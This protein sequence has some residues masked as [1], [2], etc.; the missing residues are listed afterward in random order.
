MNLVRRLK[1]IRYWIP[2]FL[3][4]AVIFVFSS[5][6]SI[7]TTDIY[8]QDFLIKKTAHVVEYGILFT[9]LYRAFRN[10]IFSE[11]RKS[12]IGSLL[13]VLAYAISDEIHQSFVPGRESRVRDV[14]FD[15]AGGFLFLYFIR[16]YLPKAPSRVRS[17]AQNFHLL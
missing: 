11:D 6:Q 9:F 17:W 10:T 7:R 1:K 2:V 3:W 4:A 15:L 5:L 8:W 12:A 14:I 16:Y 13:V